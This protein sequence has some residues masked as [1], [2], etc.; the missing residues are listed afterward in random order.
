MADVQR[1]METPLP[2][3]GAVPTE[4]VAPDTGTIRKRLPARKKAV[5]KAKRKPAKKAAAAVPKARRVS[6]RNAVSMDLSDA[7]GLVQ[8][9]HR[10]DVDTFQTISEH[11]T[12]KGKPSRK[13][14]LAALNKVFG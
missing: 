2:N 12:G 9:M 4:P 1:A 3:T 11:L 7:L 8:G 10:T 5:K 6:A 13:R 14:L